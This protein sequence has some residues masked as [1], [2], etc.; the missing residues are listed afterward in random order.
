MLSRQIVSKQ[1]VCV[2]DTSD[3]DAFAECVSPQRDVD[4][5]IAKGVPEAL[6]ILLVGVRHLR[7]QISGLETEC[8]R[9]LSFAEHEMIAGSAEKK[10]TFSSP[11]LFTNDMVPVPSGKP[12]DPGCHDPPVQP[13]ECRDLLQTATLHDPSCTGPVIKDMDETLSTSDEQVVVSALHHAH[14]RLS[15]IATGHY[16]PRSD[17]LDNPARLVDCSKRRDSLCS[18]IF[19]APACSVRNF[20]SQDARDFQ[21]WEKE[22]SKVTLS[23]TSS[24]QLAQTNEIDTGGSSKRIVAQVLANAVF[25]QLIAAMVLADG[26]VI[27]IESQNGLT[28]W[29]ADIYINLLQAF[30]VTC[31]VIFLLELVMR[32]HVDSLTAILQNSWSRFDFALVLLSVIDSC[33]ELFAGS[34]LAAVTI[35]RITRLARFARVA[36][37]FP[38]CHILYLL[39]SGLRN[40]CSTVL[41]MFI[42]IFFAAY[43][44]AIIAM[45][46]I[47]LRGD[48]GFAQ[49]LPVVDK[50]GNLLQA[51]TDYQTMAMEQ[52]GSFYVA[53]LSLLQVLTLDSIAAMYK[54]MMLEAPTWH[55]LYNCAYFSLFVF[56]GAFFLMNLVI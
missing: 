24:L 10:G 6:D 39:V 3:D 37:L 35:L 13:P 16:S 45:E 33:V 27:G 44:F 50:H 40:S 56:F 19:V 18:N 12:L 9:L 52:F 5:M 21:G 20:R 32:I 29:L 38:R 4:G 54:P 14:C 31:R 53:M 46:T 42:I 49:G 28:P 55:G 48:D 26:V 51:E 1:S 43:I 23:T 7:T 8:H 15:Q 2:S 11:S 47:P 25:H 17:Y 41:F 36:K 22:A 30:S 34:H